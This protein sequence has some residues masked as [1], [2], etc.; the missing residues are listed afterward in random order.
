[1]LSNTI[2]RGVRRVGNGTIRAIS[3]M[4]FATRFFLAVLY[5]TPAAFHRLHLA[6]GGGGDGH[7]HAHELL[8]L[9]ARGL[10]LVTLSACHTALGRFD[11]GDNLRGL[12]ANLF[13]AGAESIVGTLWELE[14]TAASTFYRAM[15]RAIAG[16]ATRFAAFRTALTETRAA[17][18]AWRDWGTFYF[19]GA[20]T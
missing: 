5:N 18:P 16:D 12:S 9:D 11:P 15:Y 14:S 17:H 10:E 8:G 13:L 6:A 1:M 20:W 4:G 19:A 2:A 3:R 7:L